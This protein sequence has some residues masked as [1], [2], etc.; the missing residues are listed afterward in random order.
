MYKLLIQSVRPCWSS[1]QNWRHATAV[2]E[3]DV[4]IPPGQ[5]T[6]TD[7]GLLT[8]PYNS[9][10]NICLRLSTEHILLPGCIMITDKRCLLQLLKQYIIMCVGH[11]L[12]DISGRVLMC[13]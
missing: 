10:T 8:M 13:L 7:G 6:Q 5:T 11:C 2:H 1:N 9:L 3:G 12:F 4:N